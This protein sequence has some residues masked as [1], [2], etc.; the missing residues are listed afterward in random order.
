MKKNKKKQKM[1]EKPRK[2]SMR[3]NKP[4]QKLLRNR[5][6]KHLLLSTKL[7]NLKRDWNRLR[8]G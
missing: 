5:Q 1:Q 7:P 6:L 2:D 8:K 3:S 4:E